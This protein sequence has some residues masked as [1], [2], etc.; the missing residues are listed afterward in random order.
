ML[1]QVH[2]H[3]GRAR[4]RK[5]LRLA[6]L[7]AGVA[8]YV[9]A[10]SL[11]QLGLYVSFMSG[12]TTS[13][14]MKFGT[15]NLG[16]AIAPGMAILFFVMGSFSSIVALDSRSLGARRAVLAII[17]VCLFT[18]MALDLAFSLK[19][20]EITV[21]AFGMGL[22][23]PVEPRVGKEPTGMTFVTGTLSR[24]GK[25]LALAVRGH[26]IPD[27]EGPWDNYWR[28]AQI[29]LQLW[30]SFAV[31]AI[32]GGLITSY[33]NALSLAPAAAVLLLLAV[34]PTP[35]TDAGSSET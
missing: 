23:N 3:R 2:A 5:Q 30:S 26:D 10:Y 20:I 7:L 21:L 29:D 18:A 16:S 34:V 32:L 13:S 6:S 28:R 11:T 1:Y 31:G 24:L 9:D 12:N 33:F 4:G 15:G 22:V 19:T 25:N 17:S 35:L 8:G 27:P 14:G